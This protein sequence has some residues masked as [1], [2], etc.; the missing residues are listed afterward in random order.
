MNHKT[1]CRVYL[2][3]SVLTVAACGGGGGAEGPAVSTLVSIALSPL[4]V[5]LAPGGTKQLTVTGTYSNGS[6]QTLSASGETF[7]SSN[8]NVVTVSAAGVVTV[9]ANAADGATATVSATDNAS[10]IATGSSTSTLVTVGQA[11]SSGPPSANSLAAAT[12]TATDN[13]MCTAITPFYWEIGDKTGALASGTFGNDSSGNPITGAT[14]FSVASASKWLYGAYI[15]QVRGSATALTAQDINFMHFTSGY[16]NMGDVVDTSEC[17][18]PTDGSPDTVNA[19]LAL[20]NPANGLPYSYQNP[21]TEG[22][23]DYDS[24]HLENHASLYGGLG[25]VP[26]AQLG[27]MVADELASNISFLYTEP[28]MA[29]GV[30]TSSDDYA[31]VLRNILSGTLFMRDALGTSPVC[32]KPSAPG[33]NATFSP[34]PE[35]WHYSIAHWVEDDP[36]TNGDGAFSSPGAF[37]FY[38]WIEAGKN[39]YGI[40]S[41][42]AASGNGEQEGYAS[43]QC[44]RLIR[45]AWDTGTEQTGAIPQ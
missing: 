1:I 9:A 8:S 12:A 37:G 39:Y 10:G 29:G 44:G 38:P 36:S 30:Y 4:T 24:G 31:I 42:Q 27:P 15:V 14:R 41:R 6:T 25:N 16:T 11:A 22:T 19:C 7:S 13:D 32:T 35:A 20:L 34:I 33:C 3:L 17:P 23:F 26:V 2:L 43:A 45:H 5:S 21:Q 40:I 18:T 28:L